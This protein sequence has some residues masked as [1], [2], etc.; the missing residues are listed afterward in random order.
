[1]S[2]DRKSRRRVLM[3]TA[4]RIGVR[5]AASASV[6]EIDHALQAAAVSSRAVAR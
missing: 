2:A 6:K 5:V 1:M 4:R 3:A